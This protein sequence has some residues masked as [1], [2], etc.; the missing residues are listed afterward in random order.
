M[1]LKFVLFFTVFGSLL[2]KAQ[3]PR[4][5]IQYYADGEYEKSLI[6]FQQLYQKSPSDDY[7]FKNYLNCLQALNKNDEAEALIK[8]E[9]QNRPKDCSLYLLYGNTLLKTNQREKAE[10]QFKIAIDKLPPDVIFVYKLATGFIDNAHYDEAIEVYEKGEKIMK[11]ISHFNYQLADLYRRKGNINQM[12]N[13]YLLALEDGSVNQMSIQ[14]L[15][16]VYLPKDKI[17]EFQ[18]MIFTR[19]EKKADDI[20]LVELLQWTYIQNKD[21]TNALRQSKA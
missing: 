16:Q 21:F 10:K 19:L 4:L 1:K 5:A 6:L 12:L 14:N 3:D 7:Y 18:T 17:Q 13:Y 2:L 8:K 15:L 20:I 9:I 11:G